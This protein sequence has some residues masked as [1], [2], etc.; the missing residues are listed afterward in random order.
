[1][2]VQYEYEC[3]VIIHLKIVKIV[4]LMLYILPQEKNQYL[5]N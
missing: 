2:V 1:M 4:C 5:K 3:H